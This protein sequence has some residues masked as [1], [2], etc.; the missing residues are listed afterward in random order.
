MRIWFPGRR[1]EV[2]RLLRAARPRARREF[3]AGLGAH[4]A[5]ASREEPR[6][7]SSRLGL[8]LV[9]TAAMLAAFGA[10]GGAGYAASAAK[11]VA[12]AADPVAIVSHVLAAPKSTPAQ[13]HRIVR[14]VSAAKTASDDDDDKPSDDQ[15]K[16]GKGCGD[17]NHVHARENECKPP[18]PK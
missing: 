3:V 5:R 17:K 11:T 12:K 13:A 6:R 7:A 4:V 18:K 8:A 14:A 2:D 16:P 9:A 1:D 10:A 15:Y